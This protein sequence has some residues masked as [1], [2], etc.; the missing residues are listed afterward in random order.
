MNNVNENIEYDNTVNEKFA[1]AVYQKMASK[2]YGIE[3]CCD[4]DLKK[5]SIKKELLDLNALK[6]CD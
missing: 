5:W 2:R 1:E 6:S 4:T 3:F